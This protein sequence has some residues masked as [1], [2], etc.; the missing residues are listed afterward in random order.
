VAQFATSIGNSLIEAVNVLGS[1]FY[2]VILGIFLVAF[3]LKH[4]NGTAVFISAFIVQIYIILSFSWPWITGQ[5]PAL[6]KSP[7]AIT[8]VMNAVSTF[9]FLWLNGIGAIGVVVLSIIFNLFFRRK[10]LTA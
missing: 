4:I 7:D 6:A 9:G 5:L 3:Y 8:S 1:L 10:A 2:G